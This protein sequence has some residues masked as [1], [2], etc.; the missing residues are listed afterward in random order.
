MNCPVCTLSVMVL[1]QG[2]PTVCVGCDKP[3]AACGCRKPL[4]P[5]SF[6]G[7]DRFCLQLFDAE[8]EAKRRA[9]GIEHGG[10]PEDEIGRP[11]NPYRALR[12]ILL[13]HARRLGELEHHRHE[14]D[15]QDLCK[16]CGL[17]GRA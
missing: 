15:D 5:E 8:M 10:D 7:F 14:Y 2:G 1:H 13:R 6:A 3:P 17:D 12:E 11:I 4:S 16:M 9:C